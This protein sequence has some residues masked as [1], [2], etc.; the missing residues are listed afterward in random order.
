MKVKRLRV[1]TRVRA[2]TEEV[3]GVAQVPTASDS[4]PADATDVE[5][6]RSKVWE[7]QRLLNNQNG[8]LSITYKKNAEANTRAYDHNHKTMQALDTSAEE[9]EIF[10]EIMKKVTLETDEGDMLYAVASEV[11]EEL[12]KD[13]D[14]L[15]DEL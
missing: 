12:E 13:Q 11:G 5:T 14:R 7:Q 3:E 10:E 6:I 1:V 9:Y 2:A 4:A 15:Q 8:R